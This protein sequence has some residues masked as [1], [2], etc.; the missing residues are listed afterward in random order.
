MNPGSRRLAGPLAVLIIALALAGCPDQDV[1]DDPDRSQRFEATLAPVGAS[2]VTGSAN[3]ELGELS[4]SVEVGADGLEPGTRIS[5]HINTWWDCTTI[6]RVLVN[7]DTLLTVPGE[8]PPRGDDYPLVDEQGRISY[9]ATRPVAELSEAL[10]AYRGMLLIELDL[11]NR[12]IYLRDD[13]HRPIACGELS[14]VD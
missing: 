13:G 3:I 8:G 6:G 5:Q 4:F 1:T 10:H 9:R 14:A 7:L 12:T 11:G 2:G